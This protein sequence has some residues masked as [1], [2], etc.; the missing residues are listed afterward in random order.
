MGGLPEKRVAMLM[1]VEFWA[2][3]SGIAQF[4]AP[5]RLWDTILFQRNK[6]GFRRVRNWQPHGL[7]GMFGRAD[8]MAQV[9]S[10]RIPFV[11]V[12]GGHHVAGTAQVGCDSKAIGQ[13]AAEHLAALGFSR[14]ACIGFPK[15]DPNLDM[16]IGGFVEALAGHDIEIFD[17][18]RDYPR[19]K[20]M[21]GSFIEPDDEVLHRWVA[22][23]PKPCALFA[24][25]DLVSARVLRACL[26]LSIQVP[27]EM[28]IVGVGD[29]PEYTLGQPIALSTVGVPWQQIGFEAANLLNRL[30]AGGPPPEKPIHLGPTGII[31][32]RSSDIL[33][34][35]DRALAEALRF[36]RIHA[37]E[38]IG[39]PDILRQVPMGR[40]VLE[41]KFRAFLDRSP[42]DEILRIRLDK[43]A[44]LLINTDQTIEAVADDTGFGTAARLTVE[45]KKR[46]EM[47]PGAYRLKM[48]TKS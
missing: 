42:R 31:A 37:C 45:F 48:R 13:T 29:L 35:P 15:E 5:P 10:W 39:V 26:H 24:S 46:F 8:L 17:P 33:A 25:S 7:I 2:L 32:R 23:L 19:L 18:D 47:P 40:R 28:A 27:E 43:A 3:R 12:F 36:I 44:Q 11:N 34:V 21:R 4:S 41:R 22:W 6:T 38:R 9:R 1:P 30:M 14:Y 16:R 20:K